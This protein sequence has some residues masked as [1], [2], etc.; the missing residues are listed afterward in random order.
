M[1]VDQFLLD[2]LFYKINSP[3]GLVYWAPVIGGGE[4][5]VVLWEDGSSMHSYL[6]P[7]NWIEAVDT[8]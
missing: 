6:Y 5:Y 8:D 4:G 2:R 3:D 7:P 1:N